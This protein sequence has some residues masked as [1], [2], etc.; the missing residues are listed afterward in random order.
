[1]QLLST[2]KARVLFPGNSI[3][4]KIAASARN[5]MRT[6]LSSSQHMTRILFAVVLATFTLEAALAAQ[7]YE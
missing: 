3:G 2:T 4:H 5:A 6:T 1:V 7:R